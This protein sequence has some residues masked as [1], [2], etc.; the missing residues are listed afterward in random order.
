MKHPE[1][2]KNSTC[3]VFYSVCLLLISCHL[4]AQETGVPKKRLPVFF[5]PTL[6]NVSLILP[7]P[8]ADN[9]VRGKADLDE[10][11]A[12]ERSRTPEQ[13]ASAQADDKEE[14]IFIFH[15]LLGAAFKAENLPITA[16][17][18]A[19][20]RNDSEV[21][22]PPLKHLYN[23]QRPYV[24]D[25][26]LHPICQLSAEPSYPSGHAMLG[27][28][29]AFTLAQVIPEMHDEI[30]LRGDDYAQ[31]R[32]IC[33]VHYRS[34]LEASRLAAAT[35]FGYMLANRRFQHELESS[36]REIRRYFSLPLQPDPQP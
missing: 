16:A 14:D 1:S 19:H 20:I 3:R 36:R 12:W 29:F 27:Y 35:L 23:R 26:E 30:Q 32:L 8:P 6:L 25:K 13:I 28:L 15:S 34:D 11:R 18:S 5:D 7:P 22:D 17:F 2:M 31:N 24:F 33:G 21:V 4:L 10:V 9:T